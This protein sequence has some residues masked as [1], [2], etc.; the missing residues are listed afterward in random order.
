MGAGVQAARPRGTQEGGK[1]GAHGALSSFEAETRNQLKA[2]A[3]AMAAPGA[4]FP[5]FPVIRDAAAFA[6][7]NP[8]G[9][10]CALVWCAVTAR[11][12]TLNPGSCERSVAP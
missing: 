6:S 5:D 4:V 8:W 2:L 1:E 12:P 7:G 9:A 10:H 3:E 11:L